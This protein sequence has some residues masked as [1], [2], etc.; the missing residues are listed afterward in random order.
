MSFNLE[1]IDLQGRLMWAKENFNNIV[2]ATSFGV[3]SSIIIDKL[4]DGLNY[5]FPVVFIDTLY[6]FQETLE[7]KDKLNDKYN[8]N[9]T[10][11]KPKGFNNKVEFEKEYGEKF[12]EKDMD[13][14]YDIVKIYPL[15]EIL[16]NMDL[17][18]SG[19][20]RQQS[21]TREGVDIIERDN[22]F[23]LQKLNPIADWTKKEVWSYIENNDIPYNPLYDQGYTSIGE[24]PLTSKPKNNDDRSGRWSEFDRC[25]C[26]LHN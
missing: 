17:W 15:K 25:E 22:K 9:L 21:S 14:F 24:E 8:L 10:T 26:G 12:W 6:H 4:Y 20:R 1:S 7:L 19:I 5:R 16:S 11:K 23:N 2:I 3:E 13:T 18:I